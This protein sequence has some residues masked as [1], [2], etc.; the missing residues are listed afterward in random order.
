MYVFLLCVHTLF[1]I[2]YSQHCIFVKFVLK[3]QSQLKQ[4][5]PCILICFSF[6]FFMRCL[7]YQDFKRHNL[8]PVDQTF[9]YL[10]NNICFPLLNMFGIKHC[11][12]LTK[13]KSV[14]CPWWGRIM[15]HVDCT[16]M[17]AALGSDTTLCSICSPEMWI[18]SLTPTVHLVWGKKV[19]EGSKAKCL[20]QLHSMFSDRWFSQASFLSRAVLNLRNESTKTLFVVQGQGFK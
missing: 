16:E 17:K 9:Q 15:F 19:S 10:L 14:N 8:Q 12:C 1:I 2:F 11:F 4:H 7:K 3:L 20:F 6:I 18:L 5:S 13:R